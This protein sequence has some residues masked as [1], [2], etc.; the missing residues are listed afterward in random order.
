LKLKATNGKSKRYSSNFSEEKKHIV[1]IFFK[2]STCFWV[3]FST[4]QV[5]F[6]SVAMARNITCTFD[7]VIIFAG[8]QQDKI[9]GKLGYIH[10]IVIM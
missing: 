10:N 4:A 3:E 1:E 2:T 6:T 5:K 7:E 9:N 8:N